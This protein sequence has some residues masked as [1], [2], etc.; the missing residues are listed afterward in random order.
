MCIMSLLHG[1]FFHRNCTGKT[2]KCNR[3]DKTVKRM[4]EEKNASRKECVPIDEKSDDRSRDKGLS[5]LF[6]IMRF[7]CNKHCS[8]L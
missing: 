7:F 3:E 5:L 4:I 8:I 1:C 6:I 2:A